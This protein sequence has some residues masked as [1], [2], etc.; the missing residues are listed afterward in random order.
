[1]RQRGA[2]K[3]NQFI[4]VNIAVARGKRVDMF[5]AGNNDFLF[6]FSGKLKQL[7]GMVCGDNMIIGAMQQ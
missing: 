1:M 7:F 5:A 2:I 3:L 6:R 4:P